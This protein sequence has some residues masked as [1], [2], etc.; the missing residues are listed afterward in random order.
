[1]NDEYEGNYN[2]YV[3]NAIFMVSFSSTCLLFN[4]DKELNWKIIKP[5]ANNANGSKTPG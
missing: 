5:L 3:H 4:I 1:M 2:N